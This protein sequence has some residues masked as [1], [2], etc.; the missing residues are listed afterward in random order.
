MHRFRLEGRRWLAENV[1]GPYDYIGYGGEL[2]RTAWARP[3]N[4]PVLLH[5]ALGAYRAA[6]GLAS[7]PKQRH[8]ALLGAAGVLK[9]LSQGGKAQELIEMVLAEDPDNAVALQMR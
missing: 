9:D 8:A 7:E 2:R 4:E 1:G 3:D 6:H 5:R